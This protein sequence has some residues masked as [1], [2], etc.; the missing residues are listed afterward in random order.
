MHVVSQLLIEAGFVHMVQWFEKCRQL[1]IKCGPQWSE[2]LF[3]LC[4]DFFDALMVSQCLTVKH[5]LYNETTGTC[6]I[7]VSAHK[8]K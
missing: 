1:W 8:V 2:T 4:E 7:Q 5:A 6:S 3:N